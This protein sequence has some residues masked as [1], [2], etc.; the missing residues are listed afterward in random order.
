MASRMPRAMRWTCS[1]LSITQGPAIRTS[2]RPLPKSLNSIG[3]GKERLLLEGE[4]AHV[5]VVG[6]ADEGLE[7]RMRLHRL[8]LEFGVELA[9]E[10]PRVT[11]DL[12]DLD[13]GAV[14]RLTGETEAGG[15]ELVLVLAVE[16]VAMAMALVN[17]G[18]L[19][20]VVRERV[21]LKLA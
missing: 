18:L 17:F 4:A 16:L 8:R 11:R 15:L 6:G 19:V 13:V 12:A 3:T 21:G 2:G 14:G 7:E 9:A 1:S 10:E 5:L 20:G